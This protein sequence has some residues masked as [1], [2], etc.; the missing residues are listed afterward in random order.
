MS[1]RNPYE[2]PKERDVI[3]GE[4]LEHAVP[5]LNF[6]IKHNDEYSDHF[7]AGC[8]YSHGGDRYSR[9]WERIVGQGP[10]IIASLKDFSAENL[11]VARRFGTG[12]KVKNESKI[13]NRNV[14]HLS[15]LNKEFISPQPLREEDKAALVALCSDVKELLAPVKEKADSLL[16]GDTYSGDVDIVS[17]SIDRVE[18]ILTVMS[19]FANKGEISRAAKSA[20]AS[21][22]PG[23][24]GTVFPLEFTRLKEACDQIRRLPFRDDDIQENERLAGNAAK[25]DE[26]IEK[27]KGSIVNAMHNLLYE[28]ME[29]A[30]RSKGR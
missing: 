6:V 5:V 14:Y 22:K 28:N 26:I 4:S 8:N 24:R 13:D 2:A 16:A 23:D 19:D 27:N 18:G 30:L 7:R 29:Q 12:H 21:E 17:Q 3:K 11:V 15:T 10:V 20:L 9:G 1:D 25:V